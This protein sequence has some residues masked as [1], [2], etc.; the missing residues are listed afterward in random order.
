LPWVLYYCFYC[1]GNSR[2]MLSAPSDV[3][4]VNDPASVPLLP[5][6]HREQPEIGFFSPIDSF[7]AASPRRHR[8]APRVFFAR[9][10]R[11]PFPLVIFWS[12]SP[13]P[14]STVSFGDRR[15]QRERGGGEL[16]RRGQ[17]E[18]GGGEFARGR[19]PT[20]G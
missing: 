8:V 6:H 2:S 5:S 10:R 4:C 3:A 17:R 11:S 1:L 20:R 14:C 13:P 12:S 9:A 15:G 19:K 18:R 16:A 7:C